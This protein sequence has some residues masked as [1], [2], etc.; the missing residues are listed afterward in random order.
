MQDRRRITFVEVDPIAGREFPFFDGATIG[1]GDCDFVLAD[2]EVSRVHAVLRSDDGAPAIEDAGSLNGTFVNG[3]RVDGAYPLTP[4]DEVRLG[5][6]VFHVREPRG[7][8]AKQTAT[9]VPAP[10]PPS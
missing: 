7:A 8:D 10:H 1:R 4:G 6:T 3:R 2:P 5:N 9:A